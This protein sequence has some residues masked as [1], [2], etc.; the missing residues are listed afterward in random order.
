MVS[1]I[2]KSS[3]V[4]DSKKFMKSDVA[5]EMAGVFDTDIT[6]NVADGLVGD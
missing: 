1:N 2:S 6:K 3:I 4:N 5:N